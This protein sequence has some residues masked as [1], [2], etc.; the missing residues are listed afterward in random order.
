MSHR[1]EPIFICEYDPAWPSQFGYLSERIFNVL[2]KIVRRIEHVGS[3][4]VPD[5]IAKPIIDVDVVLGSDADL[6]EAIRLLATIRYVHEGNLGVTGR[7]AFRA[8][9]NEV[10]HHLYV[11]SEGADELGRHIAFRDALR[12]DSLLRSNYAELKRQLAVRHAGD[13]Q[14][15]MEAKS[16]FIRAALGSRELKV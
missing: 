1:R 5:L 15:Y 4:A 7:E 10:R 3:T 16:D 9:E 11:L 13:R 12:A 6:P 8:P 2:G 14:S